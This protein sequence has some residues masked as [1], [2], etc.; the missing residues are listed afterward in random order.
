[1]SKYCQKALKD[2]KDRPTPD[3]ETALFTCLTDQVNKQIDAKE[4]AS[5]S[6]SDFVS[7]IGDGL[8]LAGS[9]TQSLI[10]SQKSIGDFLKDMQAQYRLGESIAKSYKKLSVNIGIG[11]QNQELLGKSFLS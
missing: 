9:I 1:M 10:N 8:T 6:A 5:K 2:Y 7:K 4:K 3:N 11:Y